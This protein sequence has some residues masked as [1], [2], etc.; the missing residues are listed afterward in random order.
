[1]PKFNDIKYPPTQ[2]YIYKNNKTTTNCIN[3][4]KTLPY[5]LGSFVYISLMH[6]CM[7]SGRVAQWRF[8]YRYWSCCLFQCHIQHVFNHSSNIGPVHSLATLTRTRRISL[9][10][11]HKFDMLLS[12]ITYMYVYIYI[13][14][15]CVL[16]VLFLSCL[17]WLRSCTQSR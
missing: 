14:I 2:E 10:F 16:L 11:V 6:R 8:L 15:L 12:T 17:L 7:Y 3:V 13:Y 4:W 5:N 9:S 1:M